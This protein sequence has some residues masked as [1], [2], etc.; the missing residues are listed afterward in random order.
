MSTG[1]LFR[2]PL[3]ALLGAACNRGQPVPQPTPVALCTYPRTAALAAQ[4]VLTQ[5]LRSAARWAGPVAARLN[6]EIAALP[7]HLA[8]GSTCELLA[9]DLINRA[10]LPVRPT[11]AFAAGTGFLIYQA[12]PHSKRSYI[13]VALDGNRVI[14]DSLTHIEFD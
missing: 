7:G 3:A 6:T 13:V 1:R 5:D 2:L 10:F 4:A 14:V 9:T 8:P 11:I 12:E